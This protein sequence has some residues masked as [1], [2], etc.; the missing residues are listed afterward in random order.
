MNRWWPLPALLTWALAWVV[1]AL[2]LRA[3]LGLA[4][5]F[6][7]AAVL[8]AALAV[9]AHTWWRRLFVAAGFPLSAALGAGL[10]STL[11]AWLWLL[12]LAALLLIYP[13]HSWRDAPVFP[14]PR[15]A[16]SGLARYT[17]LGPQ[18]RVLDAG[19]GLGAGLQELH[20]EW[21][22]G[23]LQG[24]EW[25]WPVR[26]LCARRCAR[27]ARISRTDIWAASWAGF[28]LVYL[29]QRPESMDRALTKAQQDMRDGSWLA[30]LEFEAVGW[31]PQAK[32]EAVP[33][34]PVWLYRLPLQK[35]PAAASTGPAH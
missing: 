16:L 24:W 22:Q 30:S 33:G 3:G 32:L 26:W 23:Q 7:L 21:P 1:F 2:C 14:T 8:A 6:G 28:D 9:R 10:A 35:R 12:P 19:C 5:A 31:V 18:T 20:R 34:K 15:G 27:F 25:S 4:M 29:F 13:V 11:P 17:G